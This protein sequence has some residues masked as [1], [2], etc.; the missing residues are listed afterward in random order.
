MPTLTG[1]WRSPHGEFHRPAKSVTT[2]PPFGKE[3]CV[4]HIH[5]VPSRRVPETLALTFSKTTTLALTLELASTLTPAARRGVITAAV[6]KPGLSRKACCT[7]LRK[8]QSLRRRNVADSCTMIC[9]QEPAF[10]GSATAVDRLERFRREGGYFPRSTALLHTML[11]GECRV[12]VRW[13]S[14]L[15]SGL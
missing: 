8:N 14:G 10:N 11:Y 9:S 15:A 13:R 7:E 2:V 1:R 6:R 3:L 12:R 4:A 5:T